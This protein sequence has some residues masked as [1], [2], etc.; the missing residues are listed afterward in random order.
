MYCSSGVRS[1]DVAEQLKEAGF[2]NVF[3]LYGGIF[4]WKNKDNPVVNSKDKETPKVHA[5]SKEWGVWL[6]KGKKVY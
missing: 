3:N 2:E 1:E 6:H 5:F 4:E